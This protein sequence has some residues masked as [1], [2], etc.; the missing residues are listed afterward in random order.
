M[1]VGAALA[2]AK[3]KTVTL[4]GDGGTQLGI[5]EMITAVDE[6]APLVYILMNDQAYGV[7]KNIQDAQYGSRHHYSALANAGLS[8]L[9]KGD[10]YP[11]SSGERHRRRIR[12]CL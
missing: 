2:G 9:C 8:D 7:I 6:N 11:T 1:G 12:S 3:A 4:L 5:A 10:W